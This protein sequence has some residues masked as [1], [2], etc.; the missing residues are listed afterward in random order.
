MLSR[1]EIIRGISPLFERA[2]GVNFV[3][4]FGSYAKGKERPFSDVDVAVHL[5]DNVQLSVD[6]YLSL[7]SDIQERLKQEIDLV[8]LNWAG[9]YLKYKIM[10]DHFPVIIKDRSSYLEYIRRTIYEYEDM[11]PYLDYQTEKRAEIL[12]EIYG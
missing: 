5:R 10:R 7:K 3:L 12:R 4:L 6:E 9:V 1:E 2:E 8:V 11:R